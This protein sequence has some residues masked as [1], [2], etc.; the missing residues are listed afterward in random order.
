MWTDSHRSP[1][2]RPLQVSYPVV[3]RFDESFQI[4]VNGSLYWVSIDRLKPALVIH[5]PGCDVTYSGHL[6]RPVSSSQGVGG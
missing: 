4:S 2:E 3:Q 6:S 5:E 1:L